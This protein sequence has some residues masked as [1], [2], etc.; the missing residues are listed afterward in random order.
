MAAGIAFAVATVLSV[1]FS[2]VR[3]KLRQ[4]EV[5]KATDDY[6]EAM[7]KE[8]GNIEALDAKASIVEDNIEALEGAI[9][10]KTDD[11]SEAIAAASDHRK[12]ADDHK[13]AGEDAL[14]RADN[15]RDQ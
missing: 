8:R 6:D 9:K 3:R 5:N 15:I 1:V 10:S 4:G 11:A 12:T 14:A 2:S 7:A 13:A